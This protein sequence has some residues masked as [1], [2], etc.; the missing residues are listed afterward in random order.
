MD[1]SAEN[2]FKTSLYAYC[3]N[4]PISRI[5]P[6]GADWYEDKQ[7]NLRWQEGSEALKAILISVHLPLLR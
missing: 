1:P 7:G 3:G 4:S 6:T 2:Y 5:D